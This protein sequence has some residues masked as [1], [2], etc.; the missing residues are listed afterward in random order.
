[1]WHWKLPTLHFVLPLSLPLV[2]TE[3]QKLITFN[4]SPSIYVWFK[5]ER[6]F[7]FSFA[8]KQLVHLSHLTIFFL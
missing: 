4:E 8:L 7:S 3:L 2:H 1:M 5:N 6:G